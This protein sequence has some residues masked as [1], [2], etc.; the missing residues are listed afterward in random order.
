MPTTGQATE[1]GLDA[2]HP[3]TATLAGAVLYGRRHVAA[4]LA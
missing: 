4:G 3:T 2:S 1:T